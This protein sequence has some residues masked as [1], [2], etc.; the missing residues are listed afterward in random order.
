MVELGFELFA[1]VFIVD[2]WRE[3]NVIKGQSTI[4]QRV[5]ARFGLLLV[6][7]EESYADHL[8]TAG[9]CGEINGNTVILADMLSSA[10][11]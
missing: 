9:L 3:P 10:V 2:A 5:V 6:D 1:R 7:F 4:G 8:L 11:A